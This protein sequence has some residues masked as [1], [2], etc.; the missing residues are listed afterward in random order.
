MISLLWAGVLVLLR[1]PDLIALEIRRAAW[2]L[3][4]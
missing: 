3:E 2:T 1:Q 4:I